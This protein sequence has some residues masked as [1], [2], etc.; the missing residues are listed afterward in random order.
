MNPSNAPSSNEALT[1]AVA[2]K[3]PA[4]IEENVP[5]WFSLLENQFSLSRITTS[6]TKF[7][8][9]LAAIPC[10]VASKLNA[11]ICKQG[12]Y[13]QLKENILDLF[14]RSKPELFERLLTTHHLVGKPSI[15]LHDLT[16][17]ASRIGVGDDIVRHKFIR[18]L[19]PHIATTLAAMPDMPLNQMGKL[20]DNLITIPQYTH[21]PPPVTAIEEAS[22]QRKEITNEPTSQR[23]SRSLSQYRNQNRRRSPSQERNQ[24]T[25]NF[26][27]QPFRPNQRPAIC[28]AHIYFAEEAKSCRPWCR[29]PNETKPKSQEN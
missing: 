14:E 15:F 17:L 27:T 18:A 2:L 16:N 7:Q 22:N 3:P 11:E 13:E 23:P 24:T 9:L 8:H 21:H 29:W 10:S 26:A 25:S 12:N 28:R 4:F 5:M 1:S 6:V 19:P 20:A